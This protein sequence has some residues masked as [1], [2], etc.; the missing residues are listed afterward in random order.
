MLD[1][2]HHHAHVEAAL[3]MNQEHGAEVPRD[4]LRE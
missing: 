1:E 4:Q 3:K 2:A